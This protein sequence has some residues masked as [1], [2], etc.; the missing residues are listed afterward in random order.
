VSWF[1]YAKSIVE[2]GVKNGVINN[3]TSIVSSRSDE[4]LVKAKRPKNCKLEQEKIES[5]LSVSTCSWCS[6]LSF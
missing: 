2:Q 6:Y 3:A 4:F 1:E 5:T